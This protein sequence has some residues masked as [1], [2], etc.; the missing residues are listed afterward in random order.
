MSE[1]AV[2][3]LLSASEEGSHDGV[4]GGA[5]GLGEEIQLD[6]LLLAGE[7]S[8]VY[9]LFPW[10]QR[11]PV[12]V[13]AEADQSKGVLTRDGGQDVLFR[14]VARSLDAVACAR[15]AEDLVGLRDASAA[16]LLADYDI[17]RAE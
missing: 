1:S 16:R 9:D 2:K 4:C 7:R 10:P 13:E 8:D 6:D 11:R 3:E 5:E 12:V 17:S 15:H 14:R